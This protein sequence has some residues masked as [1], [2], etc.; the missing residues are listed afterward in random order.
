MKFYRL[1]CGLCLVT[2][3]FAS[4]NGTS[5]ELVNQGNANASSSPANST[6]PKN[7]DSKS[8]ETLYYLDLNKPNIEQPIER[9]DRD[10][11]GSKFVQVE[12]SEVNNP[13]K[14]PVKFEVS[15][16]AKDQKKIFLGSFSLFPPNNPGKFI[17]PTHGKVKG[18]GKIILSLVASEQAKGT[19]TL[20]VGVKRIRF[21]RE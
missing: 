17:V 7:Q 8:D 10:V 1:C 21:R 5:L 4:C 2:F 9:E 19:D 15:Y 11:E 16:Q 20:R 12:V 13:Q 6:N 3:A 14:Y 18:E